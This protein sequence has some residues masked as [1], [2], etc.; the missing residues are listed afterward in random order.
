[1]GHG[2]TVI[3]DSAEQNSLQKKI[4]HRSKLHPLHP[5]GSEIGLLGIVECEDE[6]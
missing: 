3:T 5:K 1:M 6:V 4:W 2:W